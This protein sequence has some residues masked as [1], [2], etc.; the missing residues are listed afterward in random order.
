MRHGFQQESE[1]G[2]ESWEKTGLTCED[3][4]EPQSKGVKCFLI[5]IIELAAF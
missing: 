5:V 1:A 4:L 3:G 2:A